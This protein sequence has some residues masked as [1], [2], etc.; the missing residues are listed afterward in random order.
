MLPEAVALLS[1]GEADEREGDIAEFC[2]MDEEESS[3]VQRYQQEQ[4][5]CAVDEPDGCE[6]TLLAAVRRCNQYELGD[7]LPVLVGEEQVGWVSTD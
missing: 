2:R 4:E 1:G 7:F 6:G 5:L 3:C